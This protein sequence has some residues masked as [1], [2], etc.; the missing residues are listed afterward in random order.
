[1]KY[2]VNNWKLFR[3][4]LKYIPQF[5]ILTVIDNLFLGF[6]N[7]YV[8]VVFLKIVFDQIE[9][10]AALGELMNSVTFL[11]LFLTVGYV[12][13][14]IYMHL[15]E[16][17]CKYRLQS[18]IQRILFE[19]LSKIDM[20]C[21]D[22]PSYYDDY[23][24][25]MNEADEQVYSLVKDMGTLL[26]RLISVSTI[27][28][29]VS[30]IDWTTAACIVILVASSLL[31]KHL[32]TKV[33]YE[34]EEKIRIENRKEAYLNNLYVSKDCAKEIH[35]TDISSII[36]REFE[37]VISKKKDIIKRNGRKLF[38]IDFGFDFF[39]TTFFNIGIFLL[40][41]YKIQVSARISLGDFAAATGSCWKLF[42]Q[43]NSFADV[44][45]R[46]QKRD[47]YSRRFQEFMERKSNLSEQSAKRKMPQSDFQLSFC[48][49]SF[50]YPCSEEWI[51][52]DINFQ[53][54]P[55]EKIA[56]VGYNGAGKTTLVRLI[57]R[58]YEPTEGQ[59]LL[60]GFDIREYD[61]DE[62]R[63]IFGAVFQNFKLYAFS[64]A[65][66]IV[67]KPY[68]GG[69]EDEKIQRALERCGLWEKIN[70]YPEGIYS[71]MTKEFDKNGIE[72]SGGQ[73]QKM[74]LARTFAC[75]KD[76]VIMDE[77]TS[78]LD[79]ISEYEIY[80][81]MLELSEGRICIVI[82]HRLAITKDVDCILFIEKGKIVEKGSHENLLKE[83]GRYTEIW[84][85]QTENIL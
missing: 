42:W 53:I 85:V 51:L 7:S 52:R 21:Y 15:F 71:R 29:L 72:L 49:V 61:I 40:L 27:I 5:I 8:T 62:Y 50:R 33:G 68:E 67:M 44:F 38:F 32:Q 46:F 10:G 28:V 22:D 18:S 13:H 11:F 19:K 55:C 41:L 73:L 36:D 34:C 26:N 57:M 74:A 12:F 60:N 39:T 58:L 80:K 25:I 47:L 81:S 63:S 1:M 48:H 79:P 78:A 70:S 56:I 64:I 3:Y 2:I 45:V 43:L 75:E 30:T 35:A 66:N 31:L 24:W 54:N 6:L 17:R 37:G 14:V 4:A 76:V 82:S 59:I 20:A 65:E 16:P 84:N 23:I 69:L 83:N 9:A 77:P